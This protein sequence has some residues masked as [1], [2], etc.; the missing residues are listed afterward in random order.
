[1][2]N[3]SGIRDMLEIM[4]LGGMD[5]GVPCKPEDLFAGSAG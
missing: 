1:M 4:R 3:T 2:H 5:L